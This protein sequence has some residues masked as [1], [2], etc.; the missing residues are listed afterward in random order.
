M[1]EYFD[2]VDF[3]PEDAVKYGIPLKPIH[4]VRIEVQNLLLLKQV[5][6][7]LGIRVLDRCND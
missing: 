2:K 1:D 7:D 4:L 3:I 5:L 6:N